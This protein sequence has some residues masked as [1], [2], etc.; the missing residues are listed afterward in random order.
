MGF[1]CQKF[2]PENPI[3]LKVYDSNLGDMSTRKI[4]ALNITS[5]FYKEKL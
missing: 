4:A 3:C 1:A 5:L 2:V